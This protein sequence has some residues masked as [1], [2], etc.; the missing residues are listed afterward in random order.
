MKLKLDGD[1]EKPQPQSTIA[2]IDSF[3][4]IVEILCEKY[5]LAQRWKFYDS[6]RMTMNG[7]RTEQRLRVE[8][9]LPTWD[10]Y[11]LYRES[12]SCISMCVVMIQLAIKSH[13]PTEI[14]QS[15]EIELLWRETS[16]GTWLVN[17]IVSAKKEL[18]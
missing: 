13:L 15:Q 9:R 14:L 5:A 12:S 8:D 3:R 11:W 7:Y 4:H 16:V 18:G 2:A 1:A 10:E 17:D 6:C